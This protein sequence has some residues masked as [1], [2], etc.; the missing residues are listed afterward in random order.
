L[1]LKTEEYAWSG[2]MFHVKR[3]KGGLRGN[4]HIKN[5][6]TKREVKKD[7]ETYNIENYPE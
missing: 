3:G 6:G 5:Q 2:A 7:K 1:P 4:Y